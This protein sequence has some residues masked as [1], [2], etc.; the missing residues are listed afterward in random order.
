MKKDK[1][2][3]VFLLFLLLFSCREKGN[4]NRTQ[5]QDM[6]N[7]ENYDKAL[8]YQYPESISSELIEYSDT[9]IDFFGNKIFTFKQNLMNPDKAKNS[10]SSY[11]VSIYRNEYIRINDSI[12]VSIANK[13]IIGYDHES[14][15]Y[16]GADVDI[17]EFEILL[18]NGINIKMRIFSLYKF[19]SNVSGNG[20][21]SFLINAVGSYEATRGYYEF[22]DA[23]KS[24]EDISKKQIIN[25][26]G[27]NL[28]VNTFQQEDG[29]KHHY[30]KIPAGS[31]DYSFLMDIY[32]YFII[33][34]YGDIDNQ[35]ANE[36]ISTVINNI[37]N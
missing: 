2:I 21:I 19:P 33:D 32:G 24:L 35:E 25:K 15:S 16:G 11:Y 27:I 4:D 26:N 10:L 3:S 17:Q 36:Y 13:K 28:T 1:M 14:R 8:E 6:I 22:G 34:I 7:F 30:I 23:L 29:I 18:R 5:Q 12:T 9:M 37:N 31:L 20:I